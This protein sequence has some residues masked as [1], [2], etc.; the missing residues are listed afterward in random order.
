MDEVVDIGTITAP[1]VT[2]TKQ[3]ATTTERT[4]TT[5]LS[6][7]IQTEVIDSTTTFADFDEK[8]MKVTGPTLPKFNEATKDALLALFDGGTLTEFDGTPTEVDAKKAALRT[9]ITNQVTIGTG[10]GRSRRRRIRRRRRSSHKKAGKRRRTGRSRRR[11]RR[12]R[13]AKH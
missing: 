2:I 8:V 10:G 6:P 1:N 3:R 11:R 7:S 13:T 4:S 9:R 5:D 12:R